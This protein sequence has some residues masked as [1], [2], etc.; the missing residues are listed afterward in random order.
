MKL[1][2]N[3]LRI[4][5]VAV[6]A[7][8]IILEINHK[9]ET[10]NLV[11]FDYLN[12]LIQRN[13]IYFNATFY[14]FLLAIIYSNFKF[15]DNIEKTLSLN[16][17]LI[18]TF[19]IFSIIYV[20]YKINTT[21]CLRNIE[22]VDQ[23]TKLF[24][25][26]VS[27]YVYFFEIVSY[28]IFMFMSKMPFYKYKNVL[29]NRSIFSIYFYFF[30]YNLQFDSRFYKSVEVGYANLINLNM[31]IIFVFLYVHFTFLG[32]FKY[33]N[34]IVVLIISVFL[35]K[36]WY[37][38]I[39]FTFIETVSI[40][41]NNK[42][43][44]KLIES[45]LVGILIFNYFLFNLVFG[46]GTDQL[47]FLNE[48]LSVGNISIYTEQYLVL[49]NL[50]LPTI[51]SRL[52]LNFSSI[53]Y[54]F[55]FLMSLLNGLI[56]V[57]F[58]AKLRLLK[59]QSNLITFFGIVG[60]G[61]F[62]QVTER[63]LDNSVFKIDSVISSSWSFY[64]TYPARYM[65]FTFFSL[66]YLLFLKKKISI[67]LVYFILIIL[68]LDNIFIGISALLTLVIT[69]LV[70]SGFFDFQN[71]QQLK[72]KIHEQKNNFL[73]LPIA[74]LVIL[75]QTKNGYLSHFRGGYA[76]ILYLS[77]SFR[78]FH[79]IVLLYL[80][81][82]IIY[83]Y[84]NTTIYSN[85][86]T[87]VLAKFTFFY[88]IFIFISYFYFLGRSFPGNLY[89]LLF[90]FGFLNILSFHLLQ[91]ESKILFLVFPLIIFSYGVAE[92]KKIPEI[93]FSNINQTNIESQN[94]PYA[95]IQI[96]KIPQSEKYLSKGPSLMLNKYGSI[97]ATKNDLQDW[98][99]P[100]INPKIYN[101]FQC[102]FIFKK[103]QDNEYNFIYLDRLTQDYNDSMCREEILNLINIDYKLIL[104]LENTDI[105]KLVDLVFLSN[106]E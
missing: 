60:F 99:T 79:F 72:T 70:F 34:V 9:F 6:L 85:I 94:I 42:K 13:L 73:L 86:E 62:L 59:L 63:T 56:L 17:I 97:F 4:S 81:I 58:F 57:T 67:N 23:F 74:L 93:N 36:N 95:Y 78:G 26:E 25:C 69:E 47:D 2:N 83:L 41:K 31:L 44:Q 33:S 76:D 68:M 27:E 100:Y 66:F 48:I 51:L 96:D 22:K 77:H 92:I 15:S 14:I 105:Y 20:Q 12:T 35:L 11:F 104:S 43:Y 98:F 40:Y 16:S 37:L 3:I 10:E 29:L 5:Y 32:K 52:I 61:V 19:P 87:I 71:L 24:T 64:Q 75:L 39:A 21:I 102:E 18:S 1:K 103:I 106:E 49:Y 54:G 7:I 53:D 65:I 90:N 38:A 84:K 8:F 30:I 82:L 101:N 80:V 46:G 89:F 91:K 50:V 55:A 45:V 28:L 88:S